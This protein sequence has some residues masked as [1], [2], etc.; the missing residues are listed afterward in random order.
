MSAGELRHRITIQ[1][2]VVTQND[3]GQ[4]VLSPVTFA[5]RI[6]AKV[7]EEGSREVFTAQQT[8]VDVTNVLKIRWMKGIDA[9]MQVIWHEDASTDRTMSIEGRPVNSDGK[10]EYLYFPCKE[11]A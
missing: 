6:P 9:T 4:D 5:S 1:S 8:K 11:K 10:R 2:F 7:F 3:H